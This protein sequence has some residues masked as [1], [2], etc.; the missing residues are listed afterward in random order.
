MSLADWLFS[1]AFFD[2]DWLEV[3]IFGSFAIYYLVRWA[4]NG[5]RINRYREKNDNTHR[6]FHD[7][8]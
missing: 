2:L 4:M 3:I 5:F 1:H 6:E 7:Y 8:M